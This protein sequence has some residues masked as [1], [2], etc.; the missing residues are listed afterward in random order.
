MQSKQSKPCKLYH[1]F[2][3]SSIFGKPDSEK[4]KSNYPEIWVRCIKCGEEVFVKS[5]DES[6]LEY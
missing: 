2:D 5:L 6:D 4:P 1:K 3:A